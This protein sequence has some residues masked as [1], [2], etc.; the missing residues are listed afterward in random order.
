[1]KIVFLHCLL[2]IVSAM[3]HERRSLKIETPVVD[4][5]NS[6][7]IFNKTA[8]AAIIS[9][10]CNGLSNALNYDEALG[11]FPVPFRIWSAIQTKSCPHFLRG[12]HR[13]EKGHG[14]SHLQAL[15][16]F[17]FFDNDVDEARFRKN[18]EYIASTTYSSVSG[19][20][21]SFAN[22]TLFKN[23][24]EYKMDDLLIVFEDKATM[25]ITLIE[26]NFW[27]SFADEL[28]RFQ[29]DIFIFGN[30]KTQDKLEL[31]MTAYAI[32]RHGA[33]VVSQYFDLCG[34]KF[35]S[36]IKKMANLGLLKLK[37]SRNKLF[38]EG[39]CST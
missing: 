9:T 18:P 26:K 16:D 3:H 37:D 12:S 14:L 15:M 31:C 27:A 1:M 13:N 35:N 19:N 2:T 32:S 11:G 5:G 6:N 17:Y 7:W 8:Y 24:V 28:S 38:Q 29:E 4:R 30:C 39:L 20:F 34:N 10:G 22:G 21:Q 25:N 23:D 36:Q 33:K